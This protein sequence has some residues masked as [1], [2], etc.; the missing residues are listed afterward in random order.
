VLS[1]SLSPNARVEIQSSSSEGK[2]LTLAT[3]T[4]FSP[5]EWKEVLAS[6]MIAG[7]AVS[8]ADPSGLIGMTKEGLAS[9]SALLAAKTDANANALVKAV[10]AD[11]ETAGGRSAAR[12]AIKTIVTGKQPAEM[13]AALLETLGRT[14]SI[15]DAKAAADAP[16]FKAWLVQISKRV[17][18]AATEGGFLGFGGVRVSDAEKATL[19]EISRAL[20]LSA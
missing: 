12:E 18:E 17:A 20:G 4:D 6:V 11:F 19:D 1:S 15:L 16:A 5:E 7:M 3:K 8:L 14:A 9:G 10:V 2:D 13:K